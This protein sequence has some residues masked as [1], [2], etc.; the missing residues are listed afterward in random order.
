MTDTVIDRIQACTEALKLA[1]YAGRL[2]EFL[3][4][5]QLGPDQLDAV[6]K[7]LAHLKCCPAV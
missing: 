5:E 3:E 1:P 2:P 7:V 4:A 6:Y